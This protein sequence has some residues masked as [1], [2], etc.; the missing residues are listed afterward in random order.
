MRVGVAPIPPNRLVVRDTL[1]EP[2]SAGP[3][4]PRRIQADGP[5][6]H[7]AEKAVLKS[8]PVLLSLR[9]RKRDVGAAGSTGD[10]M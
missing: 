2:S 8:G 1:C 7:L 5:D 10:R 4:Q 9:R 3:D 6:N